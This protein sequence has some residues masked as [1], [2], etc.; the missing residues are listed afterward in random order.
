MSVQILR[1][2]NAIHD[3][4]F[5]RI[6]VTAGEILCVKMGRDIPAGVYSGGGL[7]GGIAAAQQYAEA[8]EQFER[9]IEQ[10]GQMLDKRGEE[11]I[12]IFIKANKRGC[13]FHVEDL[14]E[15]RLDATGKWKRFFFL[16]RPDPVLF[17]GS[18]KNGQMMFRL[19]AKKDLVIAYYELSRLVG[20]DLTVN[21]RLD[22][23][24]KAIKKYEKMRE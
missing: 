22:E 15:V 2:F 19:P 4:A 10:E 20:D 14:D 24:R 18:A 16:G 9:D 8:K 11:G 13:R 12:R 5:Y 6:Y 3:G 7:V 1:F 21:L 23:Y 17:L